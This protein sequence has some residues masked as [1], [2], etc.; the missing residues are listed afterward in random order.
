M[1]EVLKLAPEMVTFAVK[2]GIEAHRQSL[3]VEESQ[4]SWTVA[5][6]G[7]SEAALQPFLDNFNTDNVNTSWVRII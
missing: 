3:L 6:G 4:E 7:L 5:L 2:T 1:V